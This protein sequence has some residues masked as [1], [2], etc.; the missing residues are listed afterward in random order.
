M[1]I[2]CGRFACND[3]KDPWSTD[4]LQAPLFVYFAFGRRV[5]ALIWASGFPYMARNLVWLVMLYYSYC[6]MVDKSWS[7]ARVCW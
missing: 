7:D 5:L 4:Q 6:T 1:Q 3:P 2:P